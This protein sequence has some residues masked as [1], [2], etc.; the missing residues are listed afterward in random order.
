M[1]VKAFINKLNP[2]TIV[3]VVDTERRRVFY[4]RA[5]RAVFDWFLTNSSIL[6]ANPFVAEVG[7]GDYDPAIQIVIG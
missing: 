5:C 3:E 1:K 2:R 4:G 7:P 6:E